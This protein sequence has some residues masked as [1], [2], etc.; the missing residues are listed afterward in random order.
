MK[1]SEGTFLPPTTDASSDR[2]F[3][4]LLSELGGRIWDAIQRDDEITELF[5]ELADRKLARD[6]VSLEDSRLDSDWADAIM[7]MD[8][9]PETHKPLRSEVPPREWLKY[10]L[11]NSHWTGSWTKPSCE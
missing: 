8:H 5:F 11:Y 2:K 3:T 1:A 10:S 6:K 4:E 9:D 7:G